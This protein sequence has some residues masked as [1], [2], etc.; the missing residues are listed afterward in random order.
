MPDGVPGLPGDAQ[1]HECDHQ[2]DHRVG[3]VEAERDDGSTGQHAEAD[4][5]VDARVLAVG[6]E[7]RALQAAAGA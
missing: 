6:D 3:D 5:P 1:D 4:E 2:A 7:R